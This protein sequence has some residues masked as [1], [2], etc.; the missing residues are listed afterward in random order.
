MSLVGR[1]RNAGD[2][3]GRVVVV[4][5]LNVDL[6]V[7]VE[8]L[9]RAGET[10]NGSDLGRTAGGKGLNQAV[11]AARAGAPVAMVGTV[12]DDGDGG[13]LREV[14]DAEGIDTSGLVPAVGPTGTALIT[15]GADG[16]NTIVVSP[17]AN[18]LT[19]VGAS[20][21]LRLGP[22]DVVLCQAEIPADAVTA[23]L[24]AGRDAGAVTVLNQ[25]PF[26]RHRRGAVG[27]GRRA[28]RQRDGA[29][30]AR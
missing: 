12:G 16:A 22:A 20:R 30:R 2:P 13:W 7:R 21:S 28:R 10:V 24:A 29:H 5:S 19:G 1:E 23:A 4:G 6:V 14:A 9:P 11:A 15:V 8:R 18:R 25:A 17:G 27:P 26:R 3:G